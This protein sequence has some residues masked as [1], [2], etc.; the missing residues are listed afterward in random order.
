MNSINEL[1]NNHYNYLKFMKSDYMKK[2]YSQLL[3]ASENNIL[4]HENLIKKKNS[5]YNK[6]Y[7]S[8]LLVKHAELIK[9]NINKIKEILK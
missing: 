2:S 4:F 7:H 3:L 1:Y 5:I 9:I 8:K 6:Y